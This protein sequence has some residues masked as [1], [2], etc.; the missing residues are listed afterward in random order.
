MFG[1]FVVLYVAALLALQVL[2]FRLGYRSPFRLSPK[3][4][5]LIIVACGAVLAGF[6]VRYVQTDRADR[7]AK[8]SN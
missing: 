2:G 5:P 7:R 3:D 6:F 4:I 8:I 1:F